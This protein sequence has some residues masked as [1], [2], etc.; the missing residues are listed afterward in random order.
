MR[1]AWAA[2][3]TTIAI[4]TF[5]G[6]QAQARM[7]VPELSVPSVVEQ[8]ACRQATHYV[9]RPGRPTIVSQKIVCDRGPRPANCTV[10]RRSTKI[11]GSGKIVN[12]VVRKCV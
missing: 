10:V 11:H 12:N 9:T 3:G 2:I 8:V 5:G 6:P 7:L 4:V 1:L